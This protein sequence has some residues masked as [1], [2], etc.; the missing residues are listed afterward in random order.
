MPGPLEGLKKATSISPGTSPIQKGFEGAT[1]ALLGL[2]GVGPETKANLVGQLAVAGMPF[3][4]LRKMPSLRN[5]SHTLKD[6]EKIASGSGPIRTYHGTTA[7]NAALMLKEGIKLPASGEIA[8]R[9]VADLYGIPWTEWKKN[10]SWSGYGDETSRLSTAPF[11]IAQR[12]AGHFPQGEI[13]SGLNAQAR[14]M[15]EA[16]RRGIPYD[17]FYEDVHNLA[18]QKG[19]RNLY[20]VPDA[21]GLPDLMAPK[22]PGGVV[23]GVDT[24][25][26]A[27]RPHDIKDAQYLLNNLSQNKETLEDVLYEWNKHYRDMK[28]HPQN[29]KGLEVV[30]GLIEGYK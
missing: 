16:K 8:S 12:W 20:K 18:E 22:R 19:V 27:L 26:R 28:I 17:Q 10:Q 6:L 21:A 3:A 9:E 14:I 11:P 29:V 1:D 2:I 7:D 23:L 13:K 15:A 5:P 25:V 4:N 30:R 24:D